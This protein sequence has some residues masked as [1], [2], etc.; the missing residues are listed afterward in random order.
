[1]SVM[2]PRVRTLAAPARTPRSPASGSLD[3]H[4]EFVVA[5]IEV[6]GL[7]W[8]SVDLGPG[9]SDDVHHF[10]LGNRGG[11]TPDGSP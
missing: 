9:E 10:D 6:G 2:S 11:V 3:M 4:S 8:G 7:R 5:M 1:M